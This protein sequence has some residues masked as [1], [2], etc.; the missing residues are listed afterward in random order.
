M[1]YCKTEKKVLELIKNLLIL[2][3]LN[4]KC[5]GCLINMLESEIKEDARTSCVII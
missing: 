3:T 2:R 1:K 4:K 5:F